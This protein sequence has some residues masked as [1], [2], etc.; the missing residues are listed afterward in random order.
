MRPAVFLDRDGVLISDVKWEAWR[1]A[2]LLPGVGEALG[3]LRRAGMQIVV[4]SNQTAVARG[5]VTETDVNMVN[6][7]VAALTGIGIDRFYFCPHHPK[8]N[9]GSYRI[10][11]L[12]RKPSP[13][14][15]FRA[16]A[17]RDLD[18]AASQI[19]GDRLSD[20]AAG[21]A[22]GLRSTALVR[23]GAPLDAPLIESHHW[24]GTPSPNMIFDDLLSAVPWLLR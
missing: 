5:L 22:A 11:C 15:L 3:L 2:K 17:D 4:V 21:V 13:G 23:T 6:A 1:V 9:V 8:A 10:V 20:V 24:A 14:M 18:L 12:C 16:A 19:V 7:R